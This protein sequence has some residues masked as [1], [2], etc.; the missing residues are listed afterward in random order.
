[1]EAKKWQVYLLLMARCVLQAS[2][3]AIAPLLVFIEAEMKFDMILMGRILAAFPAGYLVTQVVGG[4]MSDRLGGKP[5]MTMSLLATGFCTALLTVAASFGS[6]ALVLVLFI[7]GMLQGPTFPTNAVLL[8]RWITADERSWA[9]SMTEAGSPMGG[10]IAMG[11]TPVLCTAFGWRGACYFYALFTFCFTLLWMSRAA[12]TPEECTYITEAE[13]ASLI[14]SGVCKGKDASDVPTPLKPKEPLFSIPRIPFRIMLHPSA[15]V[16]M[17]SHSIY[18]FGRYFL[19]F[20]MPTY[21]NKQLGLT[22]QKAG[23]FL[24]MPELCGAV[25]TAV[26]GIAAA[27]LSQQPGSTPLYVRKVFTSIGFFGAGSAMALLAYTEGPLFATAAMCLEGSTNAMHGSG[28]KAN[29]QDLTSKHRGGL[30]G[31]GNTVATLASTLGPLATA[32]VLHHYDSWTLNFG[33][34]AFCFW[35][36]GVSY[37][38]FAGVD[39]LDELGD[40]GDA[41]NSTETQAEPKKEATFADA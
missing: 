20:W 10:L 21:F 18:N 32:H 30:T 25:F 37:L 1:M 26:G 7:E 8:G 12:S 35:V 9:N 5:V 29:Y 6:N 24:M 11:F 28:F 19:Y 36:G 22:P 41:T 33:F 2:R 15:L 23:F 39:D 14:D 17:S 16:V 34:I 4:T 38:Q 31:V 3:L 27:N 13:M 40:N